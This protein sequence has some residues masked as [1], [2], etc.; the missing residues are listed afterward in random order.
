MIRNMA[1]VH[2][3]DPGPGWSLQRSLEEELRLKLPHM[4]GARAPPGQRSGQHLEMLVP[5]NTTRASP[6]DSVC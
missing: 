1:E 4:C 6:R 2:Q 3:E 5:L